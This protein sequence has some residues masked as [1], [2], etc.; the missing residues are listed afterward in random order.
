MLPLLISSRHAAFP[1]HWVVKLWRQLALHSMERLF[2]WRINLMAC[3]SVITFLQVSR[4]GSQRLMGSQSPF[5]HVFI[6][7]GYGFFRFLGHNVSGSP[8]ADM[9]CGVIRWLCRQPF[10]KLLIMVG[11]DGRGICPGVHGL[12]RQGLGFTVAFG[13]FLPLLHAMLI[14][15]GHPFCQTFGGFIR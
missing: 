3:F 15:T 5:C 13:G 6:L 7:P 1:S 10:K 2:C 8:M 9:A 14:R 4:R 11:I 12:P